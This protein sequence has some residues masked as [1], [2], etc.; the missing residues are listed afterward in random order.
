M[1]QKRTI[2]FSISLL[3]GQVTQGLL[4]HPY[5]T[6]QNL[7]REKVFVWLSFIPTVFFVLVLISWRLL[8]NIPICFEFSFFV[9]LFHFFLIWILNFLFYW[10]L[11]LIYFLIR[12][13]LVFWQL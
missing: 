7:V 13:S 1:A 12:F 10:Q 4:I 6:M 8:G 3:L 5:Q 9:E 11:L 2:L